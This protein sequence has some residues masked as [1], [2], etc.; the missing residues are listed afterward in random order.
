MPAQHTRAK[1]PGGLH[2]IGA[3]CW[4]IVMRLVRMKLFFAATGGTDYL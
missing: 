1:K 4:A 3:N 2:Q